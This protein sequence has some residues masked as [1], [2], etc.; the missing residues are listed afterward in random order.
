VG[1]ALTVTQGPIPFVNAQKTGLEELA[2]AGGVAM[3]VVT[4]TM[5]AMRPRPGISTYAEATE[6]VI[7]STGINGLHV[8]YDG[9][10]YAV[11]TAGVNRAI[12]RVSAGGA[13]NVATGSLANL[14]GTSRPVIA[15]SEMLLVFAAG[16]FIQKLELDTDTVSRLGGDPPE[17]SH[18]VANASRLVSNDVV[19]DKTKLRFSA[20]AQGTTTFAGFENWT[21]GPLAGFV[22]AEAR[23]DPIRA[24]HENTN[25]LFVW[26]S[27][28]LQLFGADASLFF[29]PLATREFGLSANYSVI[30]FDQQFAFLDHL[31]RFVITDGRSF[32]VVSDPIKLDLDNMT[33]I[34]DCFG[35]RVHTGTVDVL[36]WTFPTDGRTFVYQKGAGWGQWASWD[37]ETTNWTPLVVSA[38]HLRKDGNVNLVGTTAGKI[39]QYS[40]GAVTDFGS[41]INARVTTGFM[42][43]GT[44]ARK[45]CSVVRLVLRRGEA[46]GATGPQAFMRYRN[47]T[48]PWSG[49]LP[50]D[51]GGSG[52]REPVVEFRSLG[53][54]R[55]R[56]WQFEFSE[57]SSLSLVNAMEDYEVLEQ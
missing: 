23:P 53:V 14:A 17:A 54:Y 31:R 40:L 33:R 24:L 21:I 5:G 32:D 38:H 55:R 16:S 8:T 52:E 3:N 50:I 48:G 46:T 45:A 12:Y 49:P 47:D 43:R 1:E 7:D 10:L 22:T 29:A 9:K 28:S 42:N 26:G 13:V 34:D 37:D 51:L 25:E 6:D 39:G 56:Q 35:Y 57:T 11:A 44:D 30:K 27:E 36:V 19:V 41:R 15:E 2:G 18:I 20:I 4:D